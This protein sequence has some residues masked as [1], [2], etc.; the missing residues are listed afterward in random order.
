[1][2]SQ[3]LLPSLS[4]QF[5]TAIVDKDSE[6]EAERRSG[7][8][9]QAEAPMDVGVAKISSICFEMTP[10]IESSVIYALK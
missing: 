1:M 3:L 2:A 5:S 7:S 10:L 4:F 9:Q 8:I 6:N